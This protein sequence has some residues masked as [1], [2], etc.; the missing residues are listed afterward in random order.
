MI[1]IASL[2][3]RLF[4][5]AYNL[6]EVLVELVLIA[7]VIN[8]CVSML[9]GARGTRPLKGLLLLLLA[10]TV[11]VRSSTPRDS[12]ANTIGTEPTNTSVAPLAC[13]TTLT[14]RNSASSTISRS[15]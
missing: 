1:D 7:I 13:Y 10:A 9:Q 5:D 12:P 2:M 4:S 8:W 11:F 14:S 15:R 3:E 6:V